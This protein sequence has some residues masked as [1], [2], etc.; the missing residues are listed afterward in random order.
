[1]AA[2]ST[3]NGNS[4]MFRGSSSNHRLLPDSN[5][6][7]RGLAWDQAREQGFNPSRQPHLLNSSPQSLLVKSIQESPQITV[8]SGTI[9]PLGTT[10]ILSRTQKLLSS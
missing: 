2:I 1:M 6:P 3:M 10:T 5:R 4:T 8:P 7:D 9:A